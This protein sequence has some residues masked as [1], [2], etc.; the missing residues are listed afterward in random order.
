MGKFIKYS[1]NALVFCVIVILLFL[2]ISSFLYT[3][4]LHT[5]PFQI[6]DN[7]RVLILNNNLLLSIVLLVILILFLYIFRK[8]SYTV[9]NKK[10]CI[11]VATS[12]FICSIVC[13]IILKNFPRYDQLALANAAHIFKENNF[14]DLQKGYYFWC[15]PFQ[16][17]C[18]LFF[19]ILVAIYDSIYFMQMINAIFVSII[20]VCIYHITK[21]LFS[22]EKNSKLVLI[23][24]LGYLYFEFISTFIYGNIPG[25]MFALLSIIFLNKYI[26]EGKNKYIIASG[27]FIVI[28]NMLKP[29][30]LIYLVAEIIL[31]ILDT[32]VHKRAKNL[33]W[34]CATIL[35]LCMSNFFIKSFYEIRSGYELSTGMPRI[36][37]INMGLNDNTVRANGWYDDSNLYLFK[38]NDWD[39][40][41][42]K[43]D[44]RKRVLDRLNY[45]FRNPIE[46]AEF[47]KEKILTQW[48]EP[49]HQVIWLNNPIEDYDRPMNKITWS[50]YKHDGKLNKAFDLYFKIYQQLIYTMATIYFIK[51][52][53]NIEYKQILPILI[54]FGGFLFQIIWEAKSLYTIIF[55]IMLLP[56]AANELESIFEFIDKKVE[57]KQF[58]VLKK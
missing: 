51:N 39:I 41:A 43:K 26:S 36:L 4:D 44:A 56:Y 47:F 7:E 23:L 28:A 46:A 38:E 2:T 13:I 12:I 42:S 48:I 8:I 40:E 3:A 11:I 27:I 58:K 32:I 20:S 22:N 17:G 29:N 34:I 37:H 24:L 57:L 45:F 53:K 6:E 9:S 31:I 21:Q 33:V 10:I 15:Y 35:L 50:L 18:V 5:E 14:L 55:T 1:V 16:L 49:T 25:L 30:Y 54:F 19:E 52:I